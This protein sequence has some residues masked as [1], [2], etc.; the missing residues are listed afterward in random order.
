MRLLRQQTAHWARRSGLQRQCVRCRAQTAAEGTGP[1]GDEW[2]SRALSHARAVAIVQRYDGQ[3]GGG[4]GGW[5]LGRSM[6]STVM[7]G[8]G[9]ASYGETRRR[10]QRQGRRAHVLAKVDELRTLAHAAEGGRLFAALAEAERLYGEQLADGAKALRLRLGSSLVVDGVATAVGRAARS[11]TAARPTAY[12]ARGD[13]PTFARFAEADPVAASWVDYLAD[14]LGAAATQAL[15][16]AVA[17]ARTRHASPRL[18]ASA[19]EALAFAMARRGWPLDV[20]AAS[21]ACSYFL[22]QRSAQPAHVPQVLAVWQ[23]MCGMVARMPEDALFDLRFK[24]WNNVASQLVRRMSARP[25]DAWRVVAQWHAVW[26][27]VMRRVCAEAP[28]ADALR[29]RFQRRRP[30]GGARVHE[31]TLDASAVAAAVRGLAD[32]GH[33]A[34]AAELLGHSPGAL[35]VRPTAAPFN[36]LLSRLPTRTSSALPPLLPAASPLALPADPHAQLPAVL[37]LMRAAGVAPDR[38][39]LEIVAHVCCRH[40]AAEQLCAAL[41]MFASEW[42]VA[43]SERFWRV[44][45]AHP[46]IHQAAREVYEREIAPPTRLV[47]SYIPD[48]V[49]LAAMAVLWGLISKITP[50]HRDFS[51]TDKTIQY[52]HKPDSVPFYAAVLLCCVAPLAVILTWTAFVRRSFHDMN[53]GVL[54]LGISLVLNMMITNSVKNLAGRLRPDFIARCNLDPATTVEPAIGLLTSAV[55]APTDHKVFLDGMRSFPSG[56][57]SFSFA[58]LTY[59]SL[60][61]AGHLH[62][63]DR[64]GRVYKSF[65]VLV[66][67]LAALLIGVSRTKDYRHHWQDVLAGALLGVFM[68]WFGYHQ[69]YPSPVSRHDDPSVPYPPRIPEDDQDGYDNDAAS[70]SMKPF[71]RAPMNAA[72]ADPDAQAAPGAPVVRASG[73]IYSQHFVPPHAGPQQPRQA[74]NADSA[75]TA[76]GLHSSDS[77]FTPAYRDAGH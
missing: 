35:C 69:Y 45:A 74:H 42:R 6:P 44:V 67:E 14:D 36:V 64:R 27:A 68:G 55:C 9:V 40:A 31:L 20:L 73:S 49:V 61:L 1:A 52:P 15:L 32:G 26:E 50:F 59:L 43:P 25:E 58:G 66:P 76:A 4:R 46:E 7:H 24:R 60:W 17:S 63:G 2:W 8:A 23:R 57:T 71:A 70:Y 72:A 3:A 19:E 47:L 18:R 41:R 75:A 34:R 12:A 37:R 22:R 29:P 56:H 39:S 65:V 5:A 33:G 62:I 28:A 16:A 30:A 77:L 54:G 48:Y 38:R 13:S 21:R 11:Q 10:R 53:A 51:L